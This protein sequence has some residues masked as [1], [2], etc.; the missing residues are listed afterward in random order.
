MLSMGLSLQLKV[1]RSLMYQVLMSLSS[2]LDCRSL[3]DLV[4]LG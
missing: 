4:E 3:F 2:N 1:M